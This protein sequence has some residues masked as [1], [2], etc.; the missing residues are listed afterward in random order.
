MIHSVLISGA[1]DEERLYRVLGE[2]ADLGTAQTADLELVLVIDSDGGNCGSL[3]SFLEC[4]TADDRTRAALANAG[5]KIYNAQS[6]AA[7]IA[8]SFGRYREVA[9]ETAIGLHLPLLPVDMSFVDADDRLVEF[10]FESC[11]KTVEIVEEVMRRFGLDEPKLKAE[12]H[13]SGWLRLPAQECLKRGIVHRVFGEQD[14]G[15]SPDGRAKG[16]AHGESASKTILIS[17]TLTEQRLCT[18]L[19]ELRALAA[20]S[21]TPD[22]DVVLVFESSA[23]EIFSTMAFMEAVAQEELLRHLVERASVKI[24]EACFPAALIAFSWGAKRELA[25]AAKIQFSFGR[26]TLQMGN[27]N[28]LA[29]D[30]RLSAQLCKDWRRY[31]S[32]VLQ[33]MDRLGLNRD[34]VLAAELYATERLTLTAEDCLKRGLVSRLF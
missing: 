9:P 13:E 14:R 25:A 16:P 6:A 22:G 10:K 2:L 21:T 30:G 19:R 33:L 27:P 29:G 34:S 17:G 8:L 1:L 18:V 5:V 26:L 3:R 28:Q 11:R 24:Y 12:L 7:V 4:A 32:A 31:R 23:G 20:P 15:N